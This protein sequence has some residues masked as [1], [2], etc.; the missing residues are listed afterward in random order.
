[1]VS[2]GLFL[3]SLDTGYLLAVSHILFSCTSD[4]SQLIRK[5]L[6]ILTCLFEI[7]IVSHTNGFGSVRYLQIHFFEFLSISIFI[8]ILFIYLAH[9]ICVKFSPH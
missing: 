3:T 9:G 2:H 5:Y 6:G 8:I 4:T 1:M 7:L